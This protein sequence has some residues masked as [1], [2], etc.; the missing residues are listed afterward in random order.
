MCIF[1]LYIFIVGLWLIVSHFISVFL[2]ILYLYLCMYFM[3]YVLPVGVIND[4]Y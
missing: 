3:F 4:D 1:L 2:F